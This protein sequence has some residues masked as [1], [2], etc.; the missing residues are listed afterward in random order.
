[1]VE[2]LF[3]IDP[4]GALMA[5]ENMMKKNIVMPAALM[6]DGENNNLWDQFSGA[7][8]KIGLYLRCQQLVARHLK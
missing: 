8:E 2:K 7:A 6:Y 1:M 4:D 3:E 5:Y